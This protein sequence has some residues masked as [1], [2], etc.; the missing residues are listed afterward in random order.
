MHAAS[1]CHART[2]QFQ[3]KA[4]CW[5]GTTQAVWRRKRR[6]TRRRDIY[7]LFVVNCFINCPISSQL[8]CS[9]L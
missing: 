8:F 5:L 1:D 4:G 9:H 3:M 7:C 2:D 6:R